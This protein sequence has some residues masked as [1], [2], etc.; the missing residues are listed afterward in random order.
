MFEVAVLINFP[1]LRWL[2]VDQAPDSTRTLLVDIANTFL[3]LQ[4][5]SLPCGVWPSGR[6]P[7]L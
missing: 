3:Y 5:S 4:K 2:Q 6:N 7:W 1:I